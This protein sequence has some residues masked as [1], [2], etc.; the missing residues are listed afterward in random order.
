MGPLSREGRQL[1]QELAI[2]ARLCAEAVAQMGQSSF[3]G[4]DFSK[5]IEKT[6]RTL[7]HSEALFRA[8]KEHLNANGCGSTGHKVKAAHT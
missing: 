5:L 2:S 6:D 1:V 8:F 7:Q 3:S 4:C